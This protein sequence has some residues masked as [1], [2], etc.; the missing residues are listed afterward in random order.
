M[1]NSLPFNMTLNDSNYRVEEAVVAMRE[2]SRMAV[3][4]GTADMSLEEINAE[5]NASRNEG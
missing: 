5:I 4:N 2:L 1:A 3:E